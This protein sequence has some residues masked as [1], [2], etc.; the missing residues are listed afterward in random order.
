MP[1]SYAPD[2]HDTSL[3][4]H[5]EHSAALVT[6]A[7]RN[8]AHDLPAPLKRLF[9]SGKECLRLPIRQFGRFGLRRESVLEIRL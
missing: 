5:A 7:Q 6:W 4:F 3:L 1:W 2:A 9:E 8:V